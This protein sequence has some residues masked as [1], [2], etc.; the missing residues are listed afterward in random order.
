MR[1][2]AGVFLLTCVLP[3]GTACAGVSSDA[4]GSAGA[5]GSAA[6]TAPIAGASGDG[7]SPST[8]GQPSGAQGG[9]SGAGTGGE[10][11][12]GRSGAGQAGTTPIGGVGGVSGASGASGGQPNGGQSSGGATSGGPAGGS[13]GSLFQVEVQ[14]ASEVSARAPTTVG[15]VTWSTS[16][17]AP[18]S[19]KIQF[20]PT[21]DYG[22]EAPVDVN[23]ENLRTLLL[24]MKPERT[25]HFR[26]VAEVGGE[27]LTSEDFTLTT[28]DAPAPGLLG[29]VDYQVLSAAEHEPGFLLMSY[30]DGPEAGMVFILDTDGD[31]VWWYDSDLASGVAR[32]A[33]SV[34]GRDLWM[35]SGAAFLNEAVLR[36]GMD[37]L[38]LETYSNVFGTH[39]I[40]PVEGDVMALVSLFTAVEVDRAGTQ[41]TILPPLDLNV[42]PSP[43]CNAIAY[44]ATLDTYAVSNR[45]EDVYLFPRAG[46]EPGNTLLLTSIAGPNTG[47]GGYQHGVELLSNNHL[48]MFANREAESPTRSTVLEFDLESGEEVWRYESDEFTEN[49]GNAQRLPGGN[50]L[51]TYSNAGVIHETTPDQVKVLEIRTA[52]HLGYATWRPSLY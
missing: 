21:T 4:G 44:N 36:V 18:S 1:F 45:T 6:G 17:G 26:I 35:I 20:G 46:A 37:G 8:A 40:V 22:M 15:I 32:A 9:Q 14:L 34:D 47:W 30:W 29:A 43:H 24:G 7:G 3:L 16:A 51:V 23:A 52:E 10:A 11:S 28:G 49:F 19:A 25:Y 50:T 33:L 41:R 48:L 39:D 31:I 42:M 27:S 5:G 12:G 2:D 38:G 13:S